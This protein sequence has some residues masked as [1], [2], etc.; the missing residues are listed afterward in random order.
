LDEAGAIETA[1]SF[2]DAYITGDYETAYSLPLNKNMRE[3]LPAS[4]MKTAAGQVEEAYG[5]FVEQKGEKTGYSQGYFVV[6]IGGVHAQKALAYNLV[7]DKEGQIA[8]FH[9]KEIEDIDAFFAEEIQNENAH[10]VTFGSEEF[11]L[12]GTLLYPEGEGPFPAV[13][14]VHGSGANDR[15]ETIY[16]N[17]PFKDIAE[18]LAAKGIAVLR[19]D[20]RTYTHTAKYTDAEL[21]GSITV[22]NE[23]IDDARYAVEFLKT[24]DNID[25]EQIYVL[26]HSLGGNQAPRIAE[27]RDDIA[28]LI[29]MGGNVTPL[30]E[31]M[32][33]QYE[34][35]Y[36][37]QKNLDESTKALFEEQITLARDAVELIN[38]DEFGLDTD[39]ALAFG[40]PALYWMDIRTYDPT[41]IAKELN[42]PLLILQGGRDYQVPPTEFELW[43]E[44]LVDKAEYRL[45]E[46]LS[47]LFIEGEG[48]PS[49]EEYLLPGKLS[50][51][52][53]NDIAVW[54]NSK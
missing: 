24:Q 18:G 37:I 21:A 16:D 11:P 38:S 7:F 17:K 29:I 6:T 46:S 20:K 1:H 10:E 32:L 44:R 14:L 23:V 40:I 39:P 31:L 36:G 49:P 4:A 50:Q 54:I 51:E 9:Y 34:Y 26:G 52:V 2:F 42:I 30:Q 53:I 48:T 41:E 25:A 12:N 8:G 35:L 22:Y 13:V 43:R 47:H 3:V 19:Y 45:Y 27:G 28:G 15:D 33:Y 5:A